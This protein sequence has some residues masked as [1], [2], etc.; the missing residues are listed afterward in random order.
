MEDH[1]QYYNNLKHT[2]KS[3]ESKAVKQVLKDLNRTFPGDKSYNKQE[4]KDILVTYSYRNP[5]VGYCQGLNFIVAT[6]LSMG[7]TEEQCFWLYV[8]IIEK[9]LPL[10]YFTSM[11]GVI[12][13]QKVFDYLFRLKLQK[14]CRYM[15][16]LGVESSL[17]TVQWFICMFSFNFQRHILIQLWDLIFINGYTSIFQIGLG[18]LW[19]LRQEIKRK[20]DFVQVL[21]GVE[22]GCREIDDFSQFLVALN[23][24]NFRI[25]GTLVARLKVLLEVEVINEFKERFPC[26]IEPEVLVKSLDRDCKDDMECKQKVLCTSGYFTLASC[27]VV[28]I[29]GFIDQCNYPKILNAMYLRDNESIYMTGKKNHCCMLD[30][31]GGSES[32]DE[33][34]EINFMR[35]STSVSV[36]K[37]FAQISG[38]INLRDF[39]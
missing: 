3:T 39:E 21:E 32:D 14:L 17:F 25:K 38:Q 34:E 11:S 26:V 16:S 15:E 10:E 30:N 20:K 1:P 37:S 6:I 31:E 9:Y 24:R 33:Q 2:R 7:F 36:K 28:V 23:R 8:Q 29:E 35:R 19:L 4:L 5:N 18:T 13:D 12:L 22:K 27:E